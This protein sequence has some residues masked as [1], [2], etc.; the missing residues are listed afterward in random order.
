MKKTLSLLL[1]LCLLLGLLPMQALA[2]VG[3][4]LPVDSKSVRKVNL[5][6]GSLALENDYLRVIV[7]QDGSVST[8]PT[9]T[10]AGTNP[11]DRQMPFCEFVTWK[12]YGYNKQEL[13][14]PA[15][16]HLKNASFDKAPNGNAKAIKVEYDLTAKL[17]NSTLTATTAVYYELVQRKDNES[18]ADTWGVLTTVNSI[19]I[20]G[21]YVPPMT[22]SDSYMPRW[23][24][25]LNG[26]TGMGHANATDGP[27]IKMSR[28]VYNTD[29]N[30]KS[31]ESLVLTS[32]V[33][34]LSTWTAFVQGGDYCGVDIGEVYV[35]GYT[36]ANPFVGLTQASE[37]AGIDVILPDTISV[38]PGSDPTATRVECKGGAGY[39][40][41]SNKP[42]GNL[43][44]LWGFRKLVAGKEDVPTKPD[45]VNISINA[46]RLAAFAKGDD[47]TV[48]YVAD[49]A[50][51]ET[52]KKRYGADPVALISGDYKS[53]N[54]T[55][56]EFTG[57]AALLSPS[58]TATWDKTKGKLVIHKDGT[59]E[60]NGV[61]LSAP[62]FKFYQPKGGTEDHLKIAL[63]NKGFAFGITPDDN[64]AIVY[65]DIP[66]A[67]VKLEKATAD[68]AGNLVFSGNIGFQTIFNGVSFTMEKLG[69]GLNEKKEFKVNGV[70]A[71]GSFD[72]AQ[73]MALELASVKGEVNTFKGEESYAFELELNVFDLFETEATLALARS[74]KDGSLIPDELYFF[75]AASPG[76]PLI[77]PIPVGQLNGGGAG[78]KD[79]AATVNGNYFAIPPL[80][81]R[82]TLKGT[83]LHLIEGK[84]DVVLGPSEISFT[85][86]D[87]QLVGTNA[88]V[89]SQ[90]GYALKLNGQERTYNGTTYQ[91]I[92][93]AGSEKLTLNLPNNKFDVIVLDSSVELGAFGG[94]GTKD[95]QKYLYLG[96][97]A[98]GIVDGKVQ[99]PKDVPVIGGLKLLRT[100]VNLVVGGQTTAPIRN[101][102]VSEGMK[103]AFKKIDI[104]LGA[105][106]E[107]DVKIIDARIWVLVPQIVQT[108]FKRGG[109]WDVEHRWIKSL[110]EWNWADHGVQPIVQTVSL[111][112]GGED[113]SIL[114]AVETAA[115]ENSGGKTAA[116][117][118]VTADQGETPYILLAFDKDITEEQIQKAL[119]VTKDGTEITDIYWVKKAGVSEEEIGNINPNAEINATSDLITNNQDGKEYRMAI[120]R[121]TTGGEYQVNTGALEIQK[122]QP[123][124]MTPFE[125]LELNL[126]SSSSEVSGEVKYAE[127]DTKY[128]LRTYFAEE[129]GGADY[130]ID[131]QTVDNSAKISVSIPTKGTLVPTGNYYVTSFLMTE[132]TFEMED[133]TFK[134]ALAGI[135]SQQFDTPVSYTNTNEPL[136][137]QNVT[138][139]FVGNEVMTAKW[140]KM[141]DVDGY[142]VTIYRQDGNDWIDTGFGYD[143]D[144]E[145]NSINMALTVGGKAVSVSETEEAS[146]VGSAEKLQPDQTYRVGVRAYK[147][148][149]G[150]KY[151]GAE[152]LSDSNGEFLPKYTPL[153]ITLKVGNKECDKDEKGVFH[154]YVNG[155]KTNLTV[156]ADG[157]DSITVTRMDTNGALAADSNSSNIFTIPEFTG[158]LMLKI[159][160][161]SDV[162]NSTAKDVTSV[163]LLVSRDNTLP[164]LTLSDPI[165]YA[166]RDSGKYTVTGTADAGSAILYNKNN[167]TEKVY[168]DS[169][170]TFAISGTLEENQNSTV[171]SI[172]A[173]D[174]AGN[175][176][177]APQIALVA[178]Q[179]DKEV[180]PGTFD[181]S[182]GTTQQTNKFVD[183]IPGS[184]Y[185]E[186]V[187]W[188]VE[189]G[190]TQGTD[191][192]HFSPEDI[193]TR[194]EVV[195]FL[196]RA[197]GSPKPKTDAMP[198][199]DIPADSYYY[200]AVLW[201]VENGITSGTSDDTFSPDATCTR[202]QIVTFLWNSENS[203]AAGGRNPFT[204]VAADTYCTDAVLW[205]A[206]EDI[207]KGTGSTTFDPDM[208]C[209]RAQVVT[210]LWRCKK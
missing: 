40:F 167:K 131:E 108:D 158:T 165:F 206:K 27:A 190:I 194:A 24:Y 1:T 132:K 66:Y 115:P 177:T 74:N 51:L 21:G 152:G 134:T 117:F 76:I 59:V 70:K 199:T 149:E 22:D 94:T 35:D 163:F 2:Y 34:N 106:A 68:A 121:L 150:G 61:H 43:H 8:T 48:E 180:S 36:W 126:N 119:T 122:S 9:A 137:P 67:T 162:A 103:D 28:T 201:A 63:T 98:N 62:S 80:K 7:R 25:T 99:V 143:L 84:G 37:T 208:D 169:T 191:A 147:T 102:S 185:E 100:N 157:A 77:P 187:K 56:F 160:G 4:I 192:T 168:A 29:K 88:S 178:R 96:I 166:D 26:F 73:M 128:V 184:Y 75:V 186:A 11:T 170:G 173:Q 15:E 176:T 197:A 87:V 89:I 46:K 72:T 207:T 138:L 200:N 14:Y 145:T 71:K 159:D 107:V 139:E 79:L 111:E 3:D 6:S 129:Q 156:K 148:I 64:D 109:G 136:A 57:G 155:E 33:E 10:A 17:P 50:A 60:Q 30:T 19:Y 209:T 114:M 83:Y 154:A 175:V 31:T 38:T 127:K 196:W 110:P 42:G 142:A 92:Y 12:G 112:D 90:F 203:P 52:L 44:F 105:M 205:A 174:S 164:V 125:E 49:N 47:V 95:N 144:K 140:D 93:F 133:G 120:L 116:D 5:N 85:A 130:L 210:L 202:A 183:V 78:F 195:T 171:L 20:T 204:D 39:H 161:I 41:D 101:V 182:S 198:F 54:G 91:G 123:A 69:Y 97:G 32:K 58:V 113:P 13:V 179:A 146:A 188:A 81:L 135:D 153:E 45:K 118:T 86:S 124:T 181:G 16:L 65:V 172:S 141:D 55:S 53:T 193:C 151:Y 23:G 82:G 18:S 104:Y 189:N